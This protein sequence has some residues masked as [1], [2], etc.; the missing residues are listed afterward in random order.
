MILH[1]DKQDFFSKYSI[2]WHV[3]YWLFASLILFVVFSTQRYNVNIR[4]GVVIVLVLMSYGLTQLI[5]RFLVP[6]YL[7]KERLLLFSY[8]I[9]ASFILSVWIN[10]LCI[11]AILWYTA[12]RFQ[13]L[14]LPN[15]TDLLL[16]IS[17]SY[18]IILFATIVHFVKETYT[19]QVERDRIARQK[20]E[21]DL[22]LQEARLKLL[23]GQ[24]HPHFLFNMLNNLYG[25]WMEKSETTPGVI[26]KLSSLLDYTL[27][28]CNKEMV[29]LSSEV[30]FIENYLELES[31]RHDQRLK[32]NIDLVSY[33]KDLKIA[34]LVL[35]VF[36]ENAF[37][38]GVS[39]NS[40]ESH[41]YIRLQ[42][43][44]GAVRFQV[45]NNYTPNQSA[46]SGLGLNNVRERLDLI[47]KNR[48]HLSVT[49]E[50]GVFSISLSIEINA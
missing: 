27:Y 40:G 38:H 30:K 45:S 28:E 48:Y 47:Y 25:L 11:M 8:L 20:A 13:G 22:K 1:E 9:F 43:D 42:T 41:I 26:L 37:K 10:T 2:L 50:N 21:A 32:P 6:N 17:G 31:L 33:D 15:K 39:K 16:L 36:V 44:D 49:D 7:F 12:S 29:P 23:S 18:I 34:P 35:F 24:L 5:N 46:N 4:V 19:R 14:L 3:S